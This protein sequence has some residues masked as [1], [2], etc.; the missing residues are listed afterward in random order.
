MIR[1]N[2]RSIILRPERT[3]GKFKLQEICFGDE[4]TE[5]ENKEEVVKW[6]LLESVENFSDLGS[7]KA[8]EDTIKEVL[9]NRIWKVSS[10]K[11]DKGYIIELNIG[12]N[13]NMC[14]R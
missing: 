6:Y 4:C 2:I 14:I 1:D 9:G 3:F 13:I 11:Y 7:K 12:K 10:F 5:V 8:N